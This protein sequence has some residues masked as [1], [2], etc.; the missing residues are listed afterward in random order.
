MATPCRRCGT[1]KTE[2]V[3]RGA[4]RGLARVLG[5]KLRR[6]ARCQRRRWLREKD[7]RRA[8]KASVIATAP[9]P[10]PDGYNGCPRCGA[11]EFITVSRN[12]V[13]RLLRRAPMARCKSCGKRFSV[14]RA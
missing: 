13:E 11:D 10:D 12:L 5:F 9:P 6:C 1:T 7:F 4:L 2:P 3:S 8:G 14:P